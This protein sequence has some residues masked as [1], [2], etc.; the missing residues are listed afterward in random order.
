MT[1]MLNVSPRLPV[2]DLGR[3]IAFYRD[4]LGFRAG[5]GWP[6]DKPT[7]AILDRDGLALQFYVPGPE[8]PTT[9]V[10]TLSFDVEDAL[11]VHAAVQ[12]KVAIEWG[13]EVYWYGRR[14]FSFKDPDGYAIIVSQTTD[15]P[16][17]CV[18][19]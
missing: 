5:G 16:P 10:G 7:F 14:E 4:L 19:E 1:R 13:P 6:A 17:T 11:A 2:A 3:T 15:E 9:G 8:N 12:D 18:E